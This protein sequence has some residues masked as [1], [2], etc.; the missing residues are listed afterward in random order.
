MELTSAQRLDLKKHIAAALAKQDWG[1]IDMILAEYGFPTMD[2]WEGDKE[3]CVRQVLISSK[4]DDA[5]QLLNEYVDPSET[6]ATPP[7]QIETDAFDDPLSP[8]TGDRFRLFISHVHDSGS[9]AGALRTELAKRSI[10]AFVAHD[11]IEPTEEWVGVIEYALRTCDACLAILAPGFQESE[12][13][14]QETGFC[15]ARGVLVIPMEYGLMPY[16]FLGKYQA[17]PISGRRA[18][19]AGYWAGDVCGVHDPRPGGA[20]AAPIRRCQSHGRGCFCSLLRSR[21]GLSDRRRT[22]RGPGGDS[23]LH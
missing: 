16:G 5:L 4:S 18:D 6:P 19:P 22:I 10:D 17:L 21:R 15:M 7:E 12:W 3:S 2:E 1:D 9:E 8:W 13:T 23:R 20:G 14:D 11:S